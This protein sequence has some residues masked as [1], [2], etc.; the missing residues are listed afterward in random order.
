MTIAIDEIEGDLA[1]ILD[2]IARAVADWP[3]KT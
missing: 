2:R 3:S 1:G